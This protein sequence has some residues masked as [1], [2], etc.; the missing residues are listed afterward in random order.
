MESDPERTT[1]ELEAPAAWLLVWLALIALALGPILPRMSRYHGDERYY[2][3]AA[4]SMVQTGDYWVPHYL[5]GRERFHKPILTYWAMVAS[6]GLFGIG[7]L[8][9]RLPFLLAGLALVG[10]TARLAG[11]LYR[12]RSVSVLAALIIGSN[13]QFLVLSTRSTPDVLVCLFAAVSLLGFARILFQNDRSLA[14][15]VL[16]YAGAGLAVQTKGLLG[17]APVVFALL[18]RALDRGSAVP[19]RAL[20]DVRAVGLGAGLGLFWYGV[21]GWSHGS[22]LLNQFFAD[23]VTAK[24]AFNPLRILGNGLV[25]LFAVVRHFFPWTLVAGLGLA[26]AWRPGKMVVRRFRREDWFCLGWMALLILVFS[27]SGDRRTRYLAA[28]Y[29]LFTVVLARFLWVQGGTMAGG[30]IQRMTLAI[31]GAVLG[32]G[33]LV[34]AVV[35]F[36]WGAA[37]VV[38][39]LVWLLVAIYSLTSVRASRS[40]G[41]ALGLAL[42]PV[43]GFGVVENAIKPTFDRAATTEIAGHLVQAEPED[44]IVHVLI[45]QPSYAS[46]L[47]LLTGGRLRFVG[48]SATPSELA[49]AGVGL[50][51]IEDSQMAGWAATG[52]RFEPIGFE[53]H[54]W[55]VTDLLGVWRGTEVQT[56][57]DERRL[58]YYLGR[59][60]VAMPESTPGVR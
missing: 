24:V 4:I 42:V 49:A 46:Q 31:F 60:P 43:A 10:V 33:G 51:L 44:S 19:W 8:S 23:Q 53:P 29:P 34:L 2:T 3:D 47:R 45:S 38:G 32:V 55:R 6:Y 25:L 52:Y 9:S 17:C 18:F 35:G 22:A 48:S 59:R 36:W 11:T 40:W 50:V 39:G 13:L 7:L 5:D 16:A 12:E 54:D 1:W 58:T 21:V 30:R 57:I 14:A 41:V 26:L 20:L 37:L 28:G 27:F 15:A 56:A